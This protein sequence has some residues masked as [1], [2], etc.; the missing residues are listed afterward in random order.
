MEYHDLLIRVRDD[1]NIL[2]SSDLA[3]E[4]PGRLNLNLAEI[5]HDLQLIDKDQTNEKVIKKVGPTLCSARHNL[6]I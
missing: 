4:S 6:E 5:N 1:G 3:G 2:A